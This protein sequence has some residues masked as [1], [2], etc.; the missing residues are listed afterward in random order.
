MSKPDHHDET[1]GRERNGLFGLQTSLPFPLNEKRVSL[2]DSSDQPIGDNLHE[3]SDKQI[4]K[5]LQLK[6]HSNPMLLIR[7][8]SKDL[9]TKESELILL[10]KEKF[11]REHELYRLCTEYGNLSRMEIDKRL[12]ALKIE[13]DVHKVVSELIETAINDVP[14]PLRSKQRKS[15][16]PT[17]SREISKNGNISRNDSRERSYTEPRA[18]NAARL[19]LSTSKLELLADKNDRRLGHW[20]NWLNRSEEALS[21]GS[22][23]SL[24]RFRALS[25]NGF[26]KDSGKVPV[27]LESMGFDSDTMLPSPDPNID[28]HGFYNDTSMTKPPPRT[29]EIAKD[30]DL[31]FAEATIST[32]EIS[33]SISTLKQLGEL[34]DAKNEEHVRRWD[35]FMRE[36]KKD[37][38]RNNQDEQEIFGVKA[39]NLKKHDGLSKFFGSGEEEKNEESR[40]FKSL[41]R[42]I[43][44]GGIPPKYRN[45]LWFEV[46]GA[47][48]K[49]VHGE[50]DR[51]LDIARTST[52]SEIQAHVEQINLDLHRTLPSNKYFNDMATSQPGP[53]FYKLQNI[54][55]AFVAF[56]P[57]VGYS[58]GMNKIVGN[59]LLGVSEGN[60]MGTRRLSEEDVFWIFVSFT[61]DCLPKYNQLDYFHKDSLAFILRDCGIVQKAYFPRYLGEL[62]HHFEKLGVDVQVILLGWWLGA[63]TDNFASVE[64]WFKFLDSVLITE[65]V[66]VKFVSY[67][68][69]FFKLFEKTLMEHERPEDIYKLMYNLKL[70]QVNQTN[71]RFQDL[72]QI[73]N[74]FEKSMSGG[75]LEAL[76]GS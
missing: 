63:F 33:K 53:H 4:S 62:H 1:D 69:S 6:F 26:R 40:Q 55:Y 14:R 15:K 75:E 37:G 54:L 45:E 5:L 76:R 13:D 38:I 71:I 52:D 12:N 59:M 35:V 32:F 68:L 34:H 29:P 65:C 8:L 18:A 39:L 51:L 42:L 27:E 64:L 24:N 73:N 48:N 25:A 17:Q 21:S 44:S 30:S 23:T 3:L 70:S 31:T 28:R 41:H 58:Q 46:S 56:K 22:S 49:E 61:E 43:N 50:Y 72:I 19:E 7:Q 60:T 16:S 67:S 2:A 57:E 9:S 36:I 74:E 47:K 20:Y 10:R 66:E 11:Q